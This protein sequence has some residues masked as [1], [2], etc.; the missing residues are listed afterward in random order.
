[1]AHM[2][3]GS[4]RLGWNGE[5]GCEGGRGWG[6]GA[7]RLRGVGREGVLAGPDKHHKG[8]GLRIDL[9]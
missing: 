7:V 4:S 8:Q 3:L 9:H 2:R 1:M 6:E 5:E